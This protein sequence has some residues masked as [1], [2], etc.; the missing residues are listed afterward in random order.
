MNKQISSIVF[1]F[2][3]V[4]QG[5]TSYYKT[6]VCTVGELRLVQWLLLCREV[7][8]EPNTEFHSLFSRGLGLGSGVQ[9]LTA[10]WEHSI[11]LS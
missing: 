5:R 9:E 6:Q 2:V 4:D 3:H 7:C 10:K 8:P 1:C 11:S